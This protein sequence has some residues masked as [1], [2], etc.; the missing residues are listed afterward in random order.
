MSS[1]RQENVRHIFLLLCRLRRLDYR[2]YPRACETF[3]KVKK[4][5][6]ISVIKYL[7]PENAYYHSKQYLANNDEKCIQI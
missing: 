7:L 6:T 3:S 4:A 5:A 2:T 1:Q